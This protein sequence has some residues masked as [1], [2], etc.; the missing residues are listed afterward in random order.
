MSFPEDFEKMAAPQGPFGRAESAELLADALGLSARK[1]LLPSALDTQV[2]G[3]HYKNFRIQPAEFIEA[4]KLPFL[5]GC[6]IKRICRWQSKDGEQDLIKAKHE[7]DLLLEL[8]RKYP[9]IKE[10]A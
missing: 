10:L 4:N 5:E 1:S 8:R 9:T 6:I 3:S 7:I 2:A